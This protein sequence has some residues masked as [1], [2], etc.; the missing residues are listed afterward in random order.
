MESTQLPWTDTHCHLFASVFDEDRDAV[1]Q[2]ARDAGIRRIMLPNIDLPGVA[3]M[4]QVSQ[5][6]PD[7]CFPMLGLHPCSVTP[8]YR[9]TLDAMEVMFSQHEFVGV[10]ETGV[11]LYWD[12]TFRDEQIDSFE[13]H[14]VWARQFDLPVV[15]HSRESL[16]LNIQT[17]RKHQDGTLRG[18]FHCF[19]GTIEQGRQIADL[20]FHIGIGGVITYKNSPLPDVVKQ[21]PASM[22][23]LETDAPYLPPVPHRGKRNEPG[24]LLQVAETLANALSMS[25]SDLSGLTERNARQVF[26]KKG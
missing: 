8:G 6:Y 1:V 15:I 7:L 4:M 25:L 11:D 13:Q 24:Y 22:L 2:R 3:Q 10:G 19:G 26:E 9:K 18:I 21:L 5:Q 14:I 23:V 17:I 20:N 12:T 16:D